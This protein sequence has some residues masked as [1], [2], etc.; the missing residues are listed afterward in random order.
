VDAANAHLYEMAG[1]RDAA[2]AHYLAAASRT[3]SLPERHYLTLRAARL[4]T[5]V[6]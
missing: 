1:D 3:A 6:G 4:S 5:S 2:I